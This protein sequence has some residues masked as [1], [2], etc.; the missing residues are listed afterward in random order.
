M[1]FVWYG[2]PKTAEHAKLNHLIF[3]GSVFWDMSSKSF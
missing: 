2:F 3:T 1:Y